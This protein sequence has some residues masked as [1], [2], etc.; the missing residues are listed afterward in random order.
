LKALKR[1]KKFLRIASLKKTPR[2]ERRRILQ[3]GG[4]IGAI[5]PTLLAG[6]TTLLSTQS[7]GYKRMLLV[8]EKLVE[9]QPMLQHFQNKLDQQ[10]IE[11][12]VRSAIG[13]DMKSTL[14]ASIPDDV[15]VKQYII[16]LNRY[17]HSK[18]KLDDE[19]LVDLM[20][21]VG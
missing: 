3:R 19:P 12:S 15:K 10:P 16:E 21:T 13:K 7:N 14:D 17:L 11:Q 20:P 8:D 4:F 1:Y 6:L 2:A 18:R 9:F 5:L